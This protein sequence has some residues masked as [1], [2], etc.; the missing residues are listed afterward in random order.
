MW[1]AE[2]A[3]HASWVPPVKRH[4]PLERSS[5]GVHIVYDALLT[6]KPEWSGVHSRI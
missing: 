6:V 2:R 5:G 1:N 3:F 4:E